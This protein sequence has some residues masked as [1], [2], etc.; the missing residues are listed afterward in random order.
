[1]V[2]IYNRDPDDINYKE[3]IVEVTDPVE[4][5]IGQLKMLL[6][7][8]KGEVLGDPKFGLSLEE[9]I[10]TLDL[11]EESLKA[12]IYKNLRIYV[13]LFGTLGGYFNLSFYQGI[14]R[15][16]AVL[17]FFLRKNENAGPAI[18]IKVS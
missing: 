12:E 16:I 13:P 17:D 14:N 3:G 2:E 1:M 11:S 5:C 18:S 7:T 9:K 4:I 8:N 15:D 10:F 6:L